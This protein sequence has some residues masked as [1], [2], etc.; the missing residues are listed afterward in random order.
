M[1]GYFWLL[2]VISSYVIIGYS[3]LYYHR[4]FATILLVNIIGYIISAYLI[5][6]G[7]MSV[8]PS[9]ITFFYLLS[10][11]SYL[12]LPNLPKLLSTKQLLHVLKRFPPRVR[13]VLLWVPIPCVTSSSCPWQQKENSKQGRAGAG[14]GQGRAGQGVASRAIKNKE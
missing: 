8:C 7:N 1:V 12:L 5:Y 9:V 14:Q 4:L 13:T 10:I 11:W 2:K 3:R 6:K